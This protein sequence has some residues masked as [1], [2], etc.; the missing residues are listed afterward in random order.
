VHPDPKHFEEYMDYQARE[1]Y[2]VIAM[3]DFAHY[4]K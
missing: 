3:R 2:T 4:V 1:K